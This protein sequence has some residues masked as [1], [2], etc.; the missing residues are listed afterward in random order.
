MSAALGWQLSLLESILSALA[1]LWAALHTLCSESLVR[2]LGP[3]SVTR[4]GTS[5]LG[6]HKVVRA[7]GLAPGGPGVVSDKAARDESS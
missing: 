5:S 4:P 2:V 1:A 3:S 6:R 7:R